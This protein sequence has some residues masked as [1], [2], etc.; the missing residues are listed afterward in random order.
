MLSL[1]PSDV[2]FWMQQDTKSDATKSTE[3]VEKYGLE[4]GLLKVSQQ[5]PSGEEEAACLHGPPLTQPLVHGH[6][7]PG[8]LVKGEGRRGQGQQD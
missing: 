1:A 3:D 5:Q 7:P 6:L 8:A 4:V 2:T